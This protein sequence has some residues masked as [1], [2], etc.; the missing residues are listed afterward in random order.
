MGATTRG[1][2]LCIERPAG[3]AARPPKEL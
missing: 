3:G 2:A 1:D